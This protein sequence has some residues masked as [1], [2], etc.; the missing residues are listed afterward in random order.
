MGNWKTVRRRYK[1][2]IG[3][4]FS[5]R[6]EAPVRA[7]QLFDVRVADPVLFDS[8]HLKTQLIVVNT[9]EKPAT[10]KLTIIPPEGWKIHP[11]EIEIQNVTA[12]APLTTNIT[13]TPPPDACLGTFSGTLS[14][15]A[16]NQE[17]CFPFDLC[18]LSERT[19]ASTEVIT[20]DEQNR[21]IFKISNGLLQFKASADFAGCLYFLGRDSALNQLGTSF[22]NIQTKV[23]LENYSGGIRSLYLDEE[24]NFQK[25]KTHQE[26]FKA[27]P[28]EEGLWKGVRFTYETKKQEELKGILGSVAFLT[29]PFSNIIKVK[30][31]FENPTSASFRFN[32]CLW[33]SPN[34][35][36]VFQENDVIFPRGDRIFH[37]KRAEGFAISYVEPEQGW[38]VVVNKNKKQSL[39]VIAGNTDRS[40]ILSLDIGKT[41]LELFV[42]SRVLLLPKEAS[43]LEDYILLSNEEYESI[44]KTANILRA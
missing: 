3:K 16:P 36:G 29:L 7:K 12:H 17:V 5:P 28:I 4:M 23:F 21:D 15:S 33:I 1:A 24:F 43:E 14:F 26:T 25:S 32:N 11:K 27:E 22:P 13:I 9:R 19:K 2:L 18:L 39:G 41:L 37:F 20:Q 40:M 44:G 35:G 10:G 30:R 8:H 38:A 31:R 6:E 34:V 42:I